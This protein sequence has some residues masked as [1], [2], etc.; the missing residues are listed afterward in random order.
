MSVP[1]NNNCPDDELLQEVAAGIGSPELAQQTMSHVA[2]CSTCAAALRRYI[3]EFSEEQSP[4]DAVIIKQLQSSRPQWQKS[5]VRELVGGRRRFPWLKLAPAAIVAALVIVAVIEGPVLVDNFKVNLALKGVASAFTDRRTTEMRLTS[6][7]HSPYNP[8]PVELGPESGR[9]LDEVPTSLHD[10]TGAA[11]KNLQTA[12]PD[13][14][15]LQVQ[16]RALLWEA[17]PASLEKAEKDFEKARSAGLASPSLEIDLAASYFERDSRNEHPNL[18]RTLNLLSEVLSKPNLTKDDQASALFDLAIAYEKTQAWDLA[19]ETW[20]KYLHVDSTSGWTREAQQRLETAKAKASNMHRQSYSDPGFFLQQKAQGTLRPEDPEQY[21][22]KALSEWLPTAVADKNSDAYRAIQGLAEVFAEHQDFWWRD[23]LEAMRPADMD[24][25]AALS[26]AVQANDEGHYQV[27][28]DQSLIA[29]A[30]FGRR[31]NFPAT[32]WA[33]FEQ[34]YA[35]RRILNSADCLARADPLAKRLSQTNYA[36]LTAR[37]LLEQADCRN[38]YGQFAESDESLVASRRMANDSHFP[39]L[40]L[41]NLGISAGMKHLRG[42]C[43]DS[44]KE[45]VTGLTLYWQV[46]HARGERL[47]QFY[48]VMLQCS[49]ET[50]SLSSAEALIR[51]AVAMRKD[52]SANIEPDSTIDGLLHLHLANILLAQRNKKAAVSERNLSLALLNQPGEPSADK[53]RLITE[54][55]PAE[56]QFARGEAKL[57]LSTLAPVMKL[58]GPSQDKFFSLRCR[59]LL[60]DIYFSLGEDDQAVLQYQDAIDLAEASL[61]RIKNGAGRLAWL[62]ATDESYRGLVRVLLAQ[63]KDREALAQWEWYQSRPMLQSLPSDNTGTETSLNKAGKTV[64]PHHFFAGPNETRLVYAVFKD[65]LQ[66]WLAQNNSVQSKWV[67]VDQ[68]EFEELAR[69]FVKKCSTESSDLQELQ[70]EGQQLYSLLLQA[71]LIDASNSPTIIVELDRRISSLPVEALRSPDG[72]YF[73]EKYPLVYSTGSA[74]DLSLN[75]PQPVTHADSALLLDATHS[76]EPGYLPGME[77]ER[78]TILQ[79]FR[80]VQV[81][82][83]AGAHWEVVRHSLGRSRIFHYMGHGRPNGTGTGLLFNETHAIRA[84]DF[85]PELFKNSQLVVL[86]ACSSGK[87]KDGVL[88]T[89]NLVH[90]LLGAGVPRVIA[91]QWN[92]DSGTTSQVMQSFYHNIA[93]GEPVTR[94]LFDAR[95]EMVKRAPHPYYWASFTVAGLPN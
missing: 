24:A 72:R 71:L 85:T 15:W 42:N 67:F 90:A 33:S 30:Q 14:R 25:A 62:R 54:L 81:I 70:Q 32:L 88:D 55:E 26:K 91:T 12:K 36:W 94:A 22:Q 58:L 61:G 17:T 77:E 41:Q 73:G 83:S 78:R 56:F 6:I 74:V 86:A 52:P 79:T 46:I 29:V 75:K 1:L 60:G 38:I 84:Q 16:G 53:Y 10:A 44:W 7:G 87:G 39:V 19:V 8:F 9:G 20:E 27:A 11:N 64:T 82:D 93:K 51:H 2:R 50:G 69:D 57:A 80:H 35:R 43:D 40:T 66:I 37:V 65:G 89:D 48:A 5:L 4:E 23:F 18:Q 95:N 92:V 63:K 76:G 47:F 21:Q 45:A 68:R 34:V 49:L 3:K 59:K 31:H 13:P 28:E